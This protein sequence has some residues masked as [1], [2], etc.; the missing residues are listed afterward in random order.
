MKTFWI[1]IQVEICVLDVLIRVDF[2]SVV[3]NCISLIL[4]SLEEGFGIPIIEAA[5]RSKKVIANDIEIFREIAPR[6]SLLLDLKKEKQNLKLLHDY[7]KQEIHVD[8]Q[9]IFKRWSWDKSSLKLRRFLLSQL[10]HN[11]KI[12]K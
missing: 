1:Y 12:N 7:L 3:K 10:L 8:S 5:S 2:E 6:S 9:S 4:L 11:S